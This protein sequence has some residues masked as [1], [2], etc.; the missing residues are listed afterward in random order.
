[1]KYIVYVHGESKRC[2]IVPEDGTGFIECEPKLAVAGDVDLS[3][4]VITRLN[5]NNGVLCIFTKAR[6][7]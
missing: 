5:I 7:K 2:G 4:R 1:M 3:D 6:S